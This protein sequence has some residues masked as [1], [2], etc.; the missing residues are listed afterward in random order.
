[1]ESRIA[2]ALG[3]TIVIP[4][5]QQIF[6]QALGAAATLA[7][8]SEVYT[9]DSSSSNTA[10]G[11]GSNTGLASL[12][13]ALAGFAGYSWKDFE[14]LSRSSC[15]TLSGERQDEVAMFDETLAAMATVGFSLEEN[16]CWSL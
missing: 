14:Y 13:V 10:P 7:A 6:Y 2:Y 3:W 1:M 4:Q 12:Q 8:G 15:G 9:L 11:G 16:T 5:K